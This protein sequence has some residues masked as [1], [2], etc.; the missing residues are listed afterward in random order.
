M[1]ESITYRKYTIK[2][3]LFPNFRSIIFLGSQSRSQN[4]FTGKH[5]KPVRNMTMALNQ[6]GKTSLQPHFKS[7]PPK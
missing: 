4:H 6:P 2:L 1:P 5:C 7:R 3:F